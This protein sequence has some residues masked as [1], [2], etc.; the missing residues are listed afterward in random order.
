VGSCALQAVAFSIA[1]MSSPWTGAAGT[2]P[3]LSAYTDRTGRAPPENAGQVFP[4]PAMCPARPLSSLNLAFS[5][6]LDLCP[7]Q[8]WHQPPSAP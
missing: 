2:A 3:T 1:R 7:V 4:L 8:A 6:A 5:K